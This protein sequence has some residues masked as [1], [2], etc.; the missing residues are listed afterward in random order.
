LLD[1]DV[2]Y[3]ITVK[4]NAKKDGSVKATKP[5]KAAGEAFLSTL[6]AK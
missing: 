3:L 1:F 6:F 4:Q 5:V 2:I